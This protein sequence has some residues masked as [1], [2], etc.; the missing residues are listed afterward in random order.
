MIN[1]E[2]KKKEIN[3]KKL[4][5][6]KEAEMQARSRS[7]KEERKGTVSNVPGEN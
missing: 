1:D 5:L 7:Q 3:K 2:S 6:P 4:T